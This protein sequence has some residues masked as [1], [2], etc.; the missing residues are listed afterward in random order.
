MR[1]M[2]ELWRYDIGE[3]EMPPNPDYNPKKAKRSK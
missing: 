1:R 2:L 3:Q